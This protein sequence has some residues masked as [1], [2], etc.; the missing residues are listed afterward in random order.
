MSFHLSSSWVREST[1]AVDALGH[2]ALNSLKPC[3]DLWMTHA[4][5]IL[6][7]WNDHLASDETVTFWHKRITKIIPRELFFIIFEG[8]CAL[9]ISGKERLFQGITREIRNFPKINISESFFVGNKFV[10][11]GNIGQRCQWS[12]TAKNRPAKVP[13]SAFVQASKWLEDVQHRIN[14]CIQKKN[15]RHTLKR[16]LLMFR[17][18]WSLWLPT[19]RSLG[20]ESERL[21]HSG[22]NAYILNSQ[23]CLYV[24]LFLTYSKFGSER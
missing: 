19:S 3:P 21:Y 6:Y 4:W 16:V 14:L 22:R 23:K 2:C 8:S 9:K 12:R 5:E 10:S 24:R 13:S 11:E 20:L 7:R 1:S 15:N 17:T 18:P